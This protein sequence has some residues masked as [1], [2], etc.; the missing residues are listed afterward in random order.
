MKTKQEIEEAIRLTELAIDKRASGEVISRIGG[1]LAALEWVIEKERQECP[2][3]FTITLLRL[4][5]AE[6]KVKTNAP[7]N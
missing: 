6:M 5:E 4:K 1:V 3:P 7:N 2:N